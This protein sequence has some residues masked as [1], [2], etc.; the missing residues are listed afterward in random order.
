M[1]LPPGPGE[2]DV[3]AVQHVRHLLPG[4][5]GNVGHAGDGQGH[6]GQNGVVQPLGQGHRGRVRP[7]GDSQPNGQQLQ[8][9]GEDNE[10]QQG[11]PEGGGAGDHQAVPPDQP[12]RPPAPIGPGHHSQSQPQTSGQ[13]PGEYQQPQGI[14]QP[15]TDHLQHRPA[16]EQGDAQ[17]PPEHA[18]QPAQI[19]LRRRVVH[20]PV[21]L[22]PGN[23]FGA[24]GPQGCLADISLEGVQGGRVHKQKSRQAHPQQEKGHAKQLFNCEFQAVFHSQLH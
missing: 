3:V 6:S 19:A 10:Q 20:S 2:E 21:I 23:L 16:V 1:L 14:A 8:P 11:Q 9:H 24:H 4:V 5:E 15:L 7:N 13:H 22:Q 17:V 18:A 12:V